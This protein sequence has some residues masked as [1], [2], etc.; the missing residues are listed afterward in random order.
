MALGSR[1]ERKMEKGS[2]AEMRNG[3]VCGLLNVFI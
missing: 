2:S 1:L 3:G